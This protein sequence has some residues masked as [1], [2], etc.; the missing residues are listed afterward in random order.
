MLK[1]LYKFEDNKSDK[2]IKHN[3]Q[4]AFIIKTPYIVKFI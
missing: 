3:L 4:I 2:E 1:S